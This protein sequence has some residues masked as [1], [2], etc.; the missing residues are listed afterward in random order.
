MYLKQRSLYSYLRTDLVLEIQK[1]IVWTVQD[2]DR[3]GRSKW[4]SDILLGVF[5]SGRGNVYALDAPSGSA[6]KKEEE[7]FLQHLLVFC[8][9]LIHAL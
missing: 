3:I 5:A 9:K 7:K 8:R 1:A 2:L 4:K 6:K